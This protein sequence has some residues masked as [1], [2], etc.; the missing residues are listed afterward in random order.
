MAGRCYINKAAFEKAIEFLEKAKL[1][2]N[3]PERS[4]FLDDLIVQLKLQIKK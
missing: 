4:K 1:A 3:D 2:Y